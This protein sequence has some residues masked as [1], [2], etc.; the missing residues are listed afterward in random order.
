MTRTLARGFAVVLFIASGVSAQPRLDQRIGFY[1]WVG[2][3]NFTASEDLLTRA[4]RRSVET[5]SRVF[6][7]YLGARFDYVRL[8]FSSRLFSRD[9][10][11]AP[12]TLAKILALPRYRSVLEDD[13]I[14]TVVLTV[15]PIRNYGAG[16]DDIKPAA[17]VEQGRNRT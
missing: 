1:Q 2:S 14:E 6:R 5:G 16:P 12:L 7:L 17:P 15:Y 3:P 10:V 8:P 11:E 13:A 9:S 4:R